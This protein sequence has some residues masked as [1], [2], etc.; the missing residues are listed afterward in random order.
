MSVQR[1]TTP[2][3]QVRY[4]ARVKSHGR[5]V[6][7]RTFTR[8]RDAQA[9]EEDQKRRLRMGEWIDPRRG[10][11][12][13]DQVAPD[14]LLS[15]Q[16]VKRNT[17]VTER[18]SWEKH[19]KPRFGSAPVASIT[20]SEVAS[21]VGGLV[22]SGLAPSTAARHL[23]AMR[24]LLAFAVDDGRITTNVAARV[25]QPTAGRT[26]REAEFLTV[27]EIDEL[28]HACHRVE[29]GR[30][31]ADVVRVLAFAGLRWGELA[32]L[33][34]GDVVSVPGP[35]LRLQRTVIAHNKKG[36]LLLDTL[37]N[38]RARTVPLVEPL[39]PVIE[40]WCEAKAPEEW[41]FGSPQGGPLSQANWKRTVQWSE[42]V[43][44]I[45]KPKFRV[46]DLRH[47]CASIWLGAG[48]DPKVVQRILGHASATMTMD[49]YGHL[50]DHNLWEAAKRVGGISG[51]FSSDSDATGDE[52]GSA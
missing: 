35:G 20:S 25:K 52:E 22:S 41:L 17:Q 12:P 24:A 8:K 4:R 50:N 15:R 1:Y 2:S 31:Y 30:E 27:P 46:H 28:A 39:I 48:A 26:R 33:Q 13:L 42:A 14:W 37:K 21:W 34:V 36:N 49:L 38:H 18:H 47:T 43:A 6:A 5:E 16:A 32:G 23:A 19:I 11:V 40:S 9:W 3:G 44:A 51:A 10:R 29:D 7:R 45:G